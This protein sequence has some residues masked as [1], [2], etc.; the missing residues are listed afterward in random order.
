MRTQSH[1]SALILLCLFYISSDA[2]AL[3]GGNDSQDVGTILLQTGVRM[4]LGLRVNKSALDDASCFDVAPP[5][6]WE[7][8][9]C[10]GQLLRT[11]NC[12]KRIAGLIKDGYCNK[13]CGVCGTTVE[14]QFEVI[15]Q[16]PSIKELPM[17]PQPKP[18]PTTWQSVLFNAR[19]RRWDI[20]AFMSAL[21]VNVT[22]IACIVGGLTDITP[23]ETEGNWK[24]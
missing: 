9:T 3:R 20:V 23:M 11:K 10:E 15:P 5:P 8:A 12:G 6:H 18:T 14:Q 17:L 4:H 24:L 21:L 1:N 2:V 19:E 16:A 22:F 13:T 7:F